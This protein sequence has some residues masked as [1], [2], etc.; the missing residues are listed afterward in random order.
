[1][2][3][4]L[5]YALV[6]ALFA[7]TAQQSETA[8]QSDASRMH[9]ADYAAETD[10]A[11]DAAIA[12]GRSIAH[13]AE[14]GY[15]AAVTDLDARADAPERLLA[16][17]SR[18]GPELPCVMLLGRVGRGS[19]PAR[20]LLTKLAL[21]QPVAEPRRTQEPGVHND[22]RTA[23]ERTLGEAFAAAGALVERRDTRALMD[24]YTNGD[25]KVAAVAAADASRA[26]IL[27]P[28]AIQTLNGR[29]LAGDFQPLSW[30][31]LTISNPTL[32]PENPEQPVDGPE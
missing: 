14:R 4:I 23:Y 30:D 1:M 16:R 27:T 17:I 6:P 21:A 18:L 29:G 28:I 31:V 8:R 32:G 13:D 15:Q 24:I 11:I 9:T 19:E 10:R 22:D 7:C 12:A 26:G 5:A 2:R 3:S 25:I 20:E